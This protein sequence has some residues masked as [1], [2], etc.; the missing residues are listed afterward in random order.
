MFPEI[1]FP[2][3]MFSETVFP[4]TVIPETV[5]S[6]NRIFWKCIGELIVGPKHR[7]AYSTT[8]SSELSRACCLCRRRLFRLIVLKCKI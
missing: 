6:K 4:E 8:A 2:E 7:K 1:V 5:F 3:I